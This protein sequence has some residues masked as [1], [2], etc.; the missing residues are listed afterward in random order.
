MKPKPRPKTELVVE[1]VPNPNA[2]RLIPNSNDAR[3]FIL[4]STEMGSLHYSGDDERYLLVIR[5]GY[6]R[7]EVKEYLESYND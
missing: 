6:D 5:P 1:M 7:Q 2:L 3:I 4:K